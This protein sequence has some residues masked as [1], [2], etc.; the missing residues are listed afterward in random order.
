MSYGLGVDIGTTYTA[1]AVSDASGTRAVPLGRDLVVSSVVFATEGGELITGDAADGES[2]K[3]P[4]R[5]SHS[6]KRRLADPTPLKICD[7]VRSPALLMAAQLRDA[8]SLA[9]AIQGRAPGSVVL[10]CPA[11]WGPYRREHFS[12]VSRLAGV[13]DAVVVTEPEAAAMH[14]SV[15]RRLG[16]GEIVGVYDLGGG[17]FDATVLQARRHGME[18]LGTP[19]GVERLG[20]ID[21]DESLLA[22]VDQRVD[23]EITRLDPADAGQARVLLSVREACRGAK[24]ELSAATETVLRLHLPGGTR[25]VTVTR[26]EFERAIAP[27]LALTTDAF[28]RTVASA[29]L[30]ADDLAS[31]LLVGGSSQIPLVADL[32]SKTVGKPLRVGLHPKLAVALGAAALART[33]LQRSPATPPAPPAA[34]PPAA[35]PQ[36]V[37]GRP[38]GPSAPTGVPG[39]V[40][41]PGHPNPP[42]PAGPPPLAGPPIPAGPSL[43]VAPRAASV[44]E[45]PVRRRTF[46]ATPPAKTSRGRRTPVIAAAAVAVLCAGGITTAVLTSGGDSTEPPVPAAANGTSGS[47]APSGTPFLHD[48]RDVAPFHSMI[49]SEANWAGTALTADGKA[50][51]PAVAVRPADVNG[52]KDGRQVTWTGKGAAQF[53][54][55]NP[56]G[57]LDATSYVES[58][59]LTFDVVV[60]KAPTADVSLAAHCGYPC[61]AQLNATRSLRR[62]PVGQKATMRIPL[63]CFAGKGL[64]PAAVDVPFL[65]HTTGTFEAKF[66]EVRWDRSGTTGST[67]VTP[68]ADLS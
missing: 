64:N 14:H 36:P 28:R 7:V 41:T 5:A 54:V 62:L 55:Q 2:R 65:V 21:F 3:Q 8:V 42:I 11:V 53:Y 20:G 38:A 1:A 9:T 47:P 25:E 44:Q 51:Q 68:C 49:G 18:I 22:L 31:V 4:L 45:L 24:E 6:H 29:G 66:A 16:E 39:P 35:L 23:G 61:A 59:T 15:E 43:P 58:G 48:G 57:R 46:G 40:N 13:P 60:V 27:Q 19:E 34:R 52:S 32:L 37:P 33:A 67:P 50:S 10:T 12:E 30:S 26:A 56:Q 63:S 17:T